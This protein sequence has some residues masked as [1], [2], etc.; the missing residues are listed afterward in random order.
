MLCPVCKDLDVTGVNKSCL[1]YCMSYLYVKQLLR[2]IKKFNIYEYNITQLGVQSHS[3]DI[4]MHMALY[5][6][7]CGVTQQYTAKCC[8]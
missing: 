1:Q 3:N 8:D 5:M 2:V 6:V 4:V 7:R